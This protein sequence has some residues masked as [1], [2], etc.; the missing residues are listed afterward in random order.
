MM[1][2][3]YFLD[4]SDHM[5]KLVCLGGVWSYGGVKGDGSLYQIIWDPYFHSTVVDKTLY[6]GWEIEDKIKVGLLR[7]ISLIKHNMTRH[8]FS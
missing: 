2:G 4:D 8:S 3:M 1:D 7:P 6:F 5:I